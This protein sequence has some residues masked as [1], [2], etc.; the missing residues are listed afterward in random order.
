MKPTNPSKKSREYLLESEV[1]QL[2]AVAKANKNTLSA[3]RNHLIILL[4]YRHGLR[5]SELTSLKWNQVDFTAARIQIKRLKNSN[6]GVHPLAADEC[7]ILK[8]L[9]KHQ[10]LKSNWI[11]ATKSGI[12]ITRD[13]VAKALAAIAEVAKLEFFFH[14]HMWWQGCGYELAKKWFNTRLIQEYLGHKSLQ[15][16]VLYT[17]LDSERFNNLWE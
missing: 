13:G 4:G 9:K 6:S 3:T 11:F 16:T 10:P 17:A 14:H 12:P 5:I 7:R 15:H 2:I 8:K 1:E